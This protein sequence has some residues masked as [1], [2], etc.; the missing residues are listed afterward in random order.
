LAPQPIHLAA[1]LARDPVKHRAVG[2][3]SSV[4]GQ[5][6]PSAGERSWDLGGLSLIKTGARVRVRD[7]ES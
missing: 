2:G 3:G 7:V 5:P 1:H 4:V 6:V